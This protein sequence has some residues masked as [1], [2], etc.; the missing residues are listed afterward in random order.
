MEEEARTPYQ[1]QILR[2]IGLP[3]LLLG[4]WNF[5]SVYLKYEHAPSAHIQ[6]FF[7]TIVLSGT[8]LLFGESVFYVAR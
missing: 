5:A 2:V 6:S 3:W 1:W 8:G 7:L 4:L